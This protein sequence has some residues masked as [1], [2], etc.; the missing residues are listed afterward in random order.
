VPVTSSGEQSSDDDLVRPSDHHLLDEADAARADER[1]RR[2]RMPAGLAAEGGPVA[3]DPADAPFGYLTTIGRTS[4]RQHTVEIWFARQGGTVYLLSGGGDR[5]DWV[6]NLGRHPRV[7]LR[8]GSVRWAGRARIVTDPDEDRL[9]RQLVAGK[10]QPTYSG[11]LSTW[12][13]TA[14][15]VAIDVA[16]APKSGT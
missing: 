15:P 7:T 12:R 2:T 8:V 5:A 14:L 4:G 6:R 13:D 3:G 9:A 1:D 16:A 11:D 10:Y